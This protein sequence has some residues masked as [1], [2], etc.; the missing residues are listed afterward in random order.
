MPNS[1]SS[2]RH[3]LDVVAELDPVALEGLQR[4]GLLRNSTDDPF[5][6]G[7]EFAHDELRRYALA[8]LLLADGDP[9][10]RLIQADAPRWSLS[11]ARLACQALLALPDTPAT[12]LQGRLAALQ[13]TFDALAKAGHVTR[14]SDVPGE[15]LLALSDYQNQLAD[16]W[17]Q[18]LADNAVGLRRLVR[19]ADQ[20]L[21]DER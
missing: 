4:D 17:P 19:L 20:R 2:P 16:A 14:W 1:S 15:A 11:A 21:R 13:A 12:P 9:A 6:I 8:R 5:R 18:L 10:A 7:P 3:R